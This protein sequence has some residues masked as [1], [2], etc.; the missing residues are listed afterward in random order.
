MHHPLSDMFFETNLDKIGFCMIKE[1]GAYL[2]CGSLL[3]EQNCFH[4]HSHSY[5]WQ[6]YLTLMMNDARGPSQVL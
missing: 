5:P 2:E 3:L 6:F 4:I 1:A